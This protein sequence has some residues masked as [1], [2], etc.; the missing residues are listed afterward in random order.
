MEFH[1]HGGRQL[2]KY[3]LTD[4]TIDLVTFLAALPFIT[5][6]YMI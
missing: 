1:F 2:R 5:L 6:L 4:C 3:T